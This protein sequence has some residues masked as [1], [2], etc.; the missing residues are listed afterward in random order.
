M[1]KSLFYPSEERQSINTR[2]GPDSRHR[3]FNIVVAKPIWDPN[4]FASLTVANAINAVGLLQAL[5]II[6]LNGVL[7]WAGFKASVGFNAANQLSLALCAGHLSYG[8]FIAVTK[9]WFLA[10][11]RWD[12]THCALDA[13]A[14]VFFITMLQTMLVLISVERYL[15]IIKS[16][17]LNSHQV[18]MAVVNTVATGL[19]NALFHMVSVPRP[20]IS[21]SGLFCQPN[22]WGDS[23]FTVIFTWIDLVV[24]GSNMGL[25]ALSQIQSCTPLLSASFAGHSKNSTKCRL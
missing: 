15:C 8:I 9:I 24:M 11:Q 3:Q 21:A 16:I 18:R 17:K 10:Q 20:F 23:V 6:C 13:A 12:Y 1:G 4:A 5:V 2:N 25:I 19:G 22:F 14:N 7:L